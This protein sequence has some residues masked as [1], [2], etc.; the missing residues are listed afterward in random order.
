MFSV[1]PE[2]E[3]NNQFIRLGRIF[4][5]KINQIHDGHRHPG[6]FDRQYKMNAGKQPIRA[7]TKILPHLTVSRDWIYS[8]ERLKRADAFE[9]QYLYT[10]YAERERICKCISKTHCKQRI[11]LVAGVKRETC[12]FV[13]FGNKYSPN[14]RI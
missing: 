7:K 14:K 3:K 12:V 8:G 13:W 9:T 6:D 1:R 4:S 2:T 5:G 11:G 10:N